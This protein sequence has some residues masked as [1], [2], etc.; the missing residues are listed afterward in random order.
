M[1]IALRS[2]ID[3]QLEKVEDHLAP[4]QGSVKQEYFIA[5]RKLKSQ[6]AKVEKALWDIDNCEEVQWNIVRESTAEVTTGVQSSLNQLAFK[7]EDLVA[8]E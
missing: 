4:G 8:K 3:R 6:R 7:F 1:L 5:D 2:D